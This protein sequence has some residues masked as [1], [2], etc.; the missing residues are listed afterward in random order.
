MVVEELQPQVFQ[1]SNFNP[2]SNRL[3]LS[4]SLPKFTSITGFLVVQAQ[5]Y[6]PLPSSPQKESPLIVTLRD[7]FCDIKVCSV[8]SQERSLLIQIGGEIS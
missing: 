8:T 7:V 1:F 5:V 6:F 4:F 2:F 3:R